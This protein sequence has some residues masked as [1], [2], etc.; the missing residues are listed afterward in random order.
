MSTDGTHPSAGTK[1]CP[2]CG[3][4]IARSK[5]PDHI[6]HAHGGRSA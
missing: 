6:R 1:P 4:A 2:I 5:V 3:E